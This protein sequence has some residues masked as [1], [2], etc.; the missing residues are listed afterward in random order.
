MD[1]SLSVH[2]NPWRT[3]F[4]E[5]VPDTLFVEHVETLITKFGCRSLVI[6][7]RLRSSVCFVVHVVGLDIWV[8]SF[9]LSRACSHH[10]VCQRGSGASISSSTLVNLMLFVL[11]SF[12]NYFNALKISGY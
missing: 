4:V 8:E 6:I 12:A 3:D 10:L 1:E 9:A 7:F 2:R 11:F 5:H